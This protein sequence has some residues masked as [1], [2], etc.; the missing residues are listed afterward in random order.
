MSLTCQPNQVK[1][2]ISSQVGPYYML[3]ATPNK[4]KDENELDEDLQHS[5]KDDDIDVIAL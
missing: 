4:T 5:D 2:E 3:Q 1:L